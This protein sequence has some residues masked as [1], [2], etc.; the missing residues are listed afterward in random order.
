MVLATA[1][2]SGAVRS[3]LRHDVVAG[4]LTASEG[5]VDPFG[6][7][8]DRFS[9]CLDASMSNSGSY[10]DRLVRDPMAKDCRSMVASVTGA[11]GGQRLDYFRYWN[12]FLIV[13]RPL[14]AAGGIL[15]VQ[16]ASGVLMVAALLYLLIVCW[17][18]G[19]PLVAAAVGAPI[20]LTTNFIFEPLSFPHALST[21]VALATAG[22]VMAVSVRRQGHLM[23]ALVAA[24][25]VFNFVDQMYNITFAL[26]LTVGLVSAVAYRAG[27]RP[28]VSAALAVAGWFVGYLG[29]WAVRWLIAVL[30]VGPSTAVRDIYNEMVV[31][32]GNSEGHARLSLLGPLRSNLY[33]WVH[34]Y[35]APVAI[36]LVVA[37]GLFVWVAARRAL[38]P[39]MSLALPAAITPVWYLLLRNHSAVHAFFTY[40]ACSASLAVILVAL[41]V[42]LRSHATSPETSAPPRPVAWSTRS[43]L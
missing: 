37:V 41:V 29:T 25:S 42:C 20:L 28:A 18:W 6:G 10:W 40:R 3:N 21:A 15:A 24:G 27:R 30:T 34:P 17:R 5:G 23:V 26:V 16:I 11:P 43:V 38:V 36:L 35:W 8:V 39:A 22:G 33:D 9:Q 32:A 19:G 4:R 1:V 14:L 31:R 7:S 12:G 13:S 2:P